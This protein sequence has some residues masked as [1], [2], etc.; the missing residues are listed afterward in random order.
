MLNEDFFNVSLLPLQ[1]HEE[2]V[3]VRLV[4]PISLVENVQKDFFDR[5][6]HTQL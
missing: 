3:G 2:F 6:R 4:L 1:I 5:L